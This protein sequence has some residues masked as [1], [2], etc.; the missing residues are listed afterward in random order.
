MKQIIT[1]KMAMGK[2]RIE[3]M[4]TAAK[5]FNVTTNAVNIKYNRVCAGIN[6]S[7]TKDTT[8]IPIVRKANPAFKKSIKGKQL[9]EP[10]T[11]VFNI[12][13]IKVD[14][15]NNKLM[16]S[17][18][19]NSFDKAESINQMMRIIKEDREATLFEIGTFV[20]SPRDSSYSSQINYVQLMRDRIK[21]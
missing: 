1:E 12:T 4:K 11:F 16:R 9:S 5:H 19:V 10:Q 14:L 18:L 17:V 7:Y 3:A 6:S 15:N 8:K 2:T 20:I 13:N 21:S